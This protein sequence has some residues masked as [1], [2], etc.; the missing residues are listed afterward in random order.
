VLVVRPLGSF[1]CVNVEYA[2]AA[3]RADDD[4]V[5][6]HEAGCYRAADCHGDR[7]PLL[8]AATVARAELR[9]GRSW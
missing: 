3:V 1:A 8:H 2:S 7:A 5:F 6:V 9:K 4:P